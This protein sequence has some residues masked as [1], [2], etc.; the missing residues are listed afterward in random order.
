MR[1]A[2]GVTYAPKVVQDS[3]QG[4]N[5]EFVGGGRRFTRRSFDRPESDRLTGD[6]NTVSAKRWRV[7]GRS[8]VYRIERSVDR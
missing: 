1:G 7:F 2:L 5:P 8:D 6:Q 3:T 4:F